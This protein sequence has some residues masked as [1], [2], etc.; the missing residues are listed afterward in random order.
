MN[1]QRRIC[2]PRGCQGRMMHQKEFEQLHRPLLKS[3][4]IEAVTGD[5]RE[6]I[7]DT[8]PE[9]AHKLPAERALS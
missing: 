7:E 6:L 2:T 9:L 3:D 4:H 8:W 1:R 5:M